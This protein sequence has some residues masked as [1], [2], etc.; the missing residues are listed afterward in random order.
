MIP[1]GPRVPA[2]AVE[3]AQFVFHI[4]RVGKITYRELFDFRGLL[5]IYLSCQHR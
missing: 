4:L 5:P 2:G 3:E 1:P